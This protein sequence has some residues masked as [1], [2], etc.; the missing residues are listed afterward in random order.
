MSDTTLAELRATLVRAERQVQ[1]GR[2]A[3][4]AQLRDAELSWAWAA[5]RTAQDMVDRM[6]REAA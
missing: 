3:P 1:D 6:A 2:F 4:T 5:I